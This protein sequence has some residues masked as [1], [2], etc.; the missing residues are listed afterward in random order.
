MDGGYYNYYNRY[1]N[2]EA[3]M[4]ASW[5]IGFF[6]AFVILSIVFGVAE[7]QYLGDGGFGRL[8]TLFFQGIK[9][10]EA[11]DFAGKISAFVTGTGDWLAN[12]WYMFTWN[13]AG[14]TGQWNIVKWVLLY[15]ISFG[16]IASMIV[17]RF[18]GQ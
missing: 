3:R 7:M 8:E 6:M 2:D 10:G 17:A 12:L 4:K 13:Y 1:V 5:W 11:A 14:L 15:P 18:G 16:M 9:I